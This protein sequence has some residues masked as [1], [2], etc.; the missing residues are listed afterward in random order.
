MVARKTLHSLFA[1]ARSP[2]SGME[3]D[4]QVCSQQLDIIGDDALCTFIMANADSDLIYL[5]E[6]A[7]LS[8]ALQHKIVHSG[9]KTLRQFSCM[10]WNW[11]G[12]SWNWC[13]R[14]A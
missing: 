14:T 12:D 11:S 2:A 10:A 9:F 8:L 3:A 5:M 4:L 7:Q 6:D 13:S 1:V